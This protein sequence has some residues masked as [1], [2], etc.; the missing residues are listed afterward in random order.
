MAKKKTVTDCLTFTKKRTGKSKTFLN[1]LVLGKINTSIRG[2]LDK[3][4]SSLKNVSLWDFPI[5][6]VVKTPRST[7]GAWVQSPGQ[8]TDPKGTAMTGCSQ[9]NKY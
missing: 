7:L 5:G 2:K 6:L 3:N 8:G 4:I 9:I 1:L